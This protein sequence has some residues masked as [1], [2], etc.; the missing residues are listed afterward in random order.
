[1]T[2]TITLPRASWL[3]AIAAPVHAIERR[4]A[5]PVLANVLITAAGGLMRVTGTDLDIAIST[6]TDIPA[7]GS[8]QVTLPGGL[9]H[10]ILRKMPDGASVTLSWDGASASVAAGR[11]RFR[12]PTLPAD[13]FPP[14]LSAGDDAVRFSMPAANLAGMI[15]AVDYAISTE[16][17]RYYLNGIY[18]HIAGAADGPVLRMVATD[19]HRLAQIDA[20]AP[21]DSED[22]PG[23]IVPRKAVAEI[24]RLAAAAGKEA[25]A[26]ISASAAAIS[27]DFGDCTI[28]SK[29]IDG[30][31][32][33]C[34]RVVPAN[35][36]IEFTAESA[37]LAAAVD[38]VMLASGE[39]ARAV[40]CDF[41][42]GALALL[43]RSE[44]NEGVDDI[45][46]DGTG[47]IQIGVNGAYLLSALAAMAAEFVTIALSDPSSPILL[48]P[49][50]GG[51]R[52]AV[53]M[54]MRA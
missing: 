31:Y 53:I 17:T 41:S 4:H 48:R 51:D 33:D 9:L 5:I 45:E 18:L 43:A 40:R 19:G 29:L 3:A 35:N 54:P 32:P 52:L 26:E 11:S 22:L 49:R 25:V 30:T 36:D 46:V 2:T 38:R 23:I 44:G 24:A 28:T 12:L 34:G 14:P 15:K 42:R 39:K 10:D 21:T 37:R 50:G 1:M 8:G 13:D 6:S 20:L 16:E 27:V 7:G 47:E